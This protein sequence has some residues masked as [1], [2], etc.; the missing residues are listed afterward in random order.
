MSCGPAEDFSARINLEIDSPSSAANLT[1]VLLRG[2]AGT[3]R[4]HAP[5]FATLFQPAFLV[6]VF[7]FLFNFPPFR[8]LE[9]IRL[10]AEVG[11]FQVG[12]AK[13]APGAGTEHAIFLHIVHVDGDA[14][15]GG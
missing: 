2:T 1:S 3:A 9:C 11:T 5:R 6:F 13:G 4:L 12:S 15:H 14:E 7:N 10:C 8:D